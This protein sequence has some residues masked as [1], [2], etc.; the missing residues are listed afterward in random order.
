[1][2]LCDLCPEP[3][4]AFWGMGVGD[5]TESVR[6]LWTAGCVLLPAGKNAKNEMSAKKATTN[7]Q[8][9]NFTIAS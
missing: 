4:S 6:L 3:L 9:L 1:M 8:F 5:E 2:S 7:T